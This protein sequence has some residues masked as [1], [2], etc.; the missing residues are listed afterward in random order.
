VK[1]RISTALVCLGLP[2]AMACSSGPS[3][4]DT[5]SY[6]SD[7]AA[8]RANTNRVFGEAAECGDAGAGEECSPVPADRR[9]ALLPLRYYEIDP[10]F[11]VPAALRL[12]ENRPVFEMPTSTGTLRR[13]QRVGLLE[14]T[15]EGQPMSLAAFVPE[16]TRA[17]ESLFVPFADL[18]TGAETYASGRYLDLHPTATGVYAIDFNRAYNP[19]C[20]YNDTYECPFPPP[21]NRL[22]VAIRAGEK[23]PGA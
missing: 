16:G 6:L 8:A 17:I 11:N 5:S 12:S 20:A 3:A 10:R 15:L 1:S 13:M 23:A 18:T 14:F 9:P 7:V 2:A 4:P 21:S 22:K 19:Y